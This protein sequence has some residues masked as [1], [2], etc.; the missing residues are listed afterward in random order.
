MTA[1]PG[2]SF[3]IPSDFAK[4]FVARANKSAKRPGK[5]AIGISMLTITPDMHY[6]LQQRGMMPSELEQG[7]LVAQVWPSGVAA[8]AGL[9]KADIIVRING[10][11]V[12][13]SR[14]VYNMVQ[15]GMRLHMEILRNSER[16][17]V[18]LVP[19]KM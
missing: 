19:E 5:F 14:Q 1:G 10:K 2:I 18:S 16:K 15:S 12:T 11:D 4:E 6:M 9:K 13:S 8:Q 17:T 7:V 3:A